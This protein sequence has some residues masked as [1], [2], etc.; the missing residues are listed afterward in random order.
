M[1]TEKKI[2]EL[3]NETHEMI[4]VLRYIDW[5]TWEDIGSRLYCSAATI[6]RKHEKAIS[7]LRFT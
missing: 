3:D 1:E 7:E 4:L 2:M 5:M 6:K